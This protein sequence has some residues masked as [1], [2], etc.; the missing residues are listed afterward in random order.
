MPADPRCWLQRP[1]TT[2][3]TSWD[4]GE[5]RTRRVVITPAHDVCTVAAL[6]ARLP[7]S[8][9]YRRQVA[10]G[11]KGPSRYAF[12]RQ[13]VTL[14]KDGLPAR[15]VW[16]VFKRREG[17]APAYTYSSSTARRS[18]PWRTLVWRRGRRGVSEQCCEEGQTELGMDPYEVHQYTGW[19]HH[20]FCGGS[21]CTWGKKPPR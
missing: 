17:T 13:R 18:T 21:R 9:W 2:E 3:R 15:P 11:T 10:A 19:H 16:L 14:W 8:A 7:A 1:Q 4:K 6:A 5:A 12:A 20:A